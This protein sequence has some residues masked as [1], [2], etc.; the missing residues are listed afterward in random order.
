MELF[1]LL[2]IFIKSSILDVWQGSECAS[3]QQGFVRFTLNTHLVVELC[4]Y[5]LPNK[6]SCLVSYD[7]RVFRTRETVVR[8][9]SVKKVFLKISQKSQE[10]TCVGVSF[11]KISGLNAYNFITKRL[12]HRCF[13]VNIAK[14]LRTTIFKEHLQWLLLEPCQTS[15]MDHYQ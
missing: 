15:I 8:R 2:A 3:L 6:H 11:N 10:N 1:A 9:C 12:Q 4:R 14:F 13:P 5:V 7:R